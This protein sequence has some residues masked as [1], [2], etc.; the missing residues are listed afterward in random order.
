MFKKNIYFTDNYDDTIYKCNNKISV[1]YDNFGLKLCG[2]RK[3]FVFRIKL[4][5]G[6]ICYVG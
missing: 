5:E 4:D 2:T 3:W 6:S 1:F